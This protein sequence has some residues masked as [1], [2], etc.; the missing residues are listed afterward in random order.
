MI[1][2]LRSNPGAAARVA[3][4]IAG[5]NRGGVC[6]VVAT[7]DERYWLESNWTR[8]RRT[9]LA[10]VA[11]LAADVIDEIA[12][13]GAA[14]DESWDAFLGRVA[15]TLDRRRA[16]REG[17]GGEIYA[18]GVSL[19]GDAHPLRKAL[20]EAG[21]RLI[22]ENALA[23][24]AG[25]LR[26]GLTNMRHRLTAESEHR[27]KT[28]SR[29]DAISRALTREATAGGAGTDPSGRCNRE[30]FTALAG[31]LRESWAHD[32]NLPRTP[33]A[34]EA[35]FEEF[36]ADCAPISESVIGGFDDL[37]AADV[38]ALPDKA[39]KALYLEDCLDRL[40]P[41]ARRFV[42]VAY[43]LGDVLELSV[44]GFCERENI[45]RRQFYR[46]LDGALASL[47]EC[48]TTR[49]EGEII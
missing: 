2:L 13:T 35:Y 20:E 21:A 5:G 27:A 8:T 37:R 19:F 16:A 46:L 29:L 26:R 15:R 14:R 12:E 44:K 32:R 11:P 18:I 41:Q 6:G 48:L 3:P 45:Q 40:A 7:S 47:R 17:R 38:E 4:M 23:V 42:E 25:A 28:W 49:I 24:R 39:A 31:R 34:I 36:C 33:G 9:L 43:R 10:I 30:H 1:A 22:G